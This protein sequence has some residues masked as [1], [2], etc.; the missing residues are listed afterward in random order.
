MADDTA[1]TSTTELVDNHTVCTQSVGQ[2]SRREALKRSLVHVLPLS[3]TLV[4]LS[5][6]LFNK[7]WR[8]LGAPHQNVIL[9]AFQFAAKGHEIAMGLSLSA[10]VMHRI[11]YA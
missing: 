8:D 6:N 5:F 3:I 1:S 11:R 4:I 7:H 9:Q 10:I 2:T